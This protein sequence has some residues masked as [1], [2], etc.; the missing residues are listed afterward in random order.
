MDAGHGK[1]VFLDR[2][3]VIVRDVGP[4]ASPESLQPFPSASG[5]IRRLND[6]GYAVVVV[7]NQTVVARGLASEEDVVRA[8][9]HLAR[10]LDAEGAVVDRFYF[11][12]HHPSATV[13]AYRLDCGCRKPR[14]GMFEQAARELGL[15]L[16]RSFAVGDRLSDI[17]AGARVG[18]RTILV[19][20]GKHDAPPIESPE[21]TGTETIQ[22][23]YTCAD[24]SAAVDVIVKES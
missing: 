17:A 6:Q 23:T 10:V 4:T 24:L 16:T 19:Q 14:S 11:C 8:H 5:A 20:T 7:S 2:D 18:C 9:E 12:P 22:A 15:D 21:V 1:A 13:A 3:G